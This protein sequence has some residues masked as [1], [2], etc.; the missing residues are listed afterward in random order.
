M[1]FDFIAN[2]LFPPLCVACGDRIGRGVVCE[3]CLSGIVL[4][5]GF[6]CGE[7]HEPAGVPLVGAAAGASVCH[8]EFP[9]ILGAATDYTDKTV[10][11]LI[12]HLKFRSINRAAEPL[13]E[14]VVRYLQRTGSLIADLWFDTP[15]VIVPIPL[16]T[17]RRRTRGYNQAELIARLVAC[18]LEIPIVTDA[19][20]RSKHTKPQSDAASVAERLENIRG[21]Y[22]VRGSGS[23]GGAASNVIR[24]ANIILI[25]DVSTTG[26]TFL[27]ASRTLKAAGAE[28]IIAV[29]V[30]KT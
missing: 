24:G 19:L 7:C 30:A 25:D 11:S 28:K 13:A 5:A 20:I 8:P 18:A 17:Q 3:A 12:H 29:A 23:V 26:A 16:S 22:A 4:R 10:Q 15:F 21:A 9:Y 1:S 14:L 27:E 2:I 6:L